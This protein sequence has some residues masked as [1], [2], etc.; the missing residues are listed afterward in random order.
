MKSAHVTAK[1]RLLLI[2]TRTAELPDKDGHRP[3]EALYHDKFR[4]AIATCWACKSI[5]SYLLARAHCALSATHTPNAINRYIHTCSRCEGVSR[6]SRSVATPLNLVQI[7]SV[8]L[9][10]SFW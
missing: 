5:D 8:H 9:H 4:C 10:L 2:Y 3:H 7:L 1:V 6:Q